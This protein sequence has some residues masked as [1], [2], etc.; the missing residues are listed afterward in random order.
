MGEF[1]LPSESLVVLI[2][3]PYSLT[4]FDFFFAMLKCAIDVVEDDEENV[5]PG[6][7]ISGG[8]YHAFRFRNRAPI[9][10]HPSSPCLNQV[11]SLYAWCD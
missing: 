2:F 11:Y 6:D 1:D 8:P 4:A 10:G 3:S 5:W 7:K 9:H